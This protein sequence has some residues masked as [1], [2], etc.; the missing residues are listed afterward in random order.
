MLEKNKFENVL[1]SLRVRKGKAWTQQK[2]AQELGVSRRTYVGWENGDSLPSQHDLKNIVAVFSL[3]S[4]DEDELYCAAAQVP[5]RIHNLPFPPSLYFTGREKLLKQL[6]KLFHES[7]AVAISQPVTLSGLGGIGKTQLALEYAH[8]CYREKIYR[9]VIWV[10]ADERLTIEAS[11][12]S[13]ARLFGLSEQDEKESDCAV[14]VVRQWLEAHTDWLLIMD[15]ADDLGLARSFLPVAHRGHILFTTRSQIVGTFA[16]QLEVQEMEPEEGLRFLLRR[17]KV[18][19]E[20]DVLDDVDTDVRKAASQLVALLGA[21]PLALDQAGAYV[22]E[23]GVSFDEYTKLFRE[24]RNYL[25]H[26]QGTLESEQSDH[27]ESAATTIVMSI[28]RAIGRP[29][30]DIN[31]ATIHILYLCVFLQPDSIPEEILHRD[32]TLTNVGMVA[33]NEGIA[34]L[35]R[36]SL[37]KHNASEKTFSIHR[38]VQAVALDVLPS[39]QHKDW[40][41]RVMELLASVFPWDI[42]NYKN[43]QLCERLLPHVLSCITWQEFDPPLT[44]EMLHRAASYLRARKHPIDIEPMLTRARAISE[45]HYGTNHV[46]TATALKNLADC[47]IDQGR[48]EEGRCMLERALA[49]FEKNLGNNPLAVSKIL[50]SLSELHRKHGESEEAEQL[51]LRVLAEMEQH[52]GPDHPDVAKHLGIMASAYVFEGKDE[53]AIPLFQRAREIFDQ[54]IAL[55]NMDEQDPY[56]YLTTTGVSTLLHFQGRHDEAEEYFLKVVRAEERLL[57]P[58]HPEVIDF[59]KTAIGT[60]HHFGRHAEAEALEAEIREIGRDDGLSEE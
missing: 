27:P 59:K 50:M 12:H 34:T 9:A 40:K 54:Q 24:H 47:Y 36:Y 43:W 31:S 8:R 51:N 25:M 21:H 22:E 29:G 32:L 28:K 19:Q 16:K 4:K 7:S 23:T 1:K 44:I 42:Y 55:G 60:L 15:N 14:Q 38:L 57:G 17:A 45:R 35:R 49:I 5:P 10:D 6:R 48:E 2:T 33:F 52:L 41:E 30:T 37:I 13:I 18:L 20:D 3:S 39:E 56:I 53:Q 26:R 58:A 11:Y 46:A